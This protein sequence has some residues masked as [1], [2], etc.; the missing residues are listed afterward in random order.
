M[1]RLT[2]IM[3]ERLETADLETGEILDVPMGTAYGLENR[4]LVTSDWRRCGSQTPA[5]NYS[6]GHFCPNQEVLWAD[7]K[8]RLWS[9][10]RLTERLP[11]SG[12]SLS[13]RKTS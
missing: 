9:I 12:H 6:S 8:C 10:A 2:K 13:S 3:Q 5:P 1:T 7:L 11:V 4:R